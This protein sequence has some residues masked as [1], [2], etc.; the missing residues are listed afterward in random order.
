MVE[1]ARKVEVELGGGDSQEAEVIGTDPSTDIA[2]LKVDDTKGIEPLELGDSSKVEVGDPVVAIG[3][4]FALDRTVTSGI[5][6]ALRQGRSR[7]RMA[8]RSAT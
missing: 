2:L 3:N 4:P 1:G 6:S 5:V 8:S 7:R